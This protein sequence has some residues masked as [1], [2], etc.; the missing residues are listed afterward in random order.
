MLGVN[1][2]NVS[3]YDTVTFA[4]SCHTALILWTTVAFDPRIHREPHHED[5]HRIMFEVIGGH[6]QPHIPSDISSLLRVRV[7]DTKHRK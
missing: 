7:R 5:V 2:K 4:G 1:R 6:L 3:F